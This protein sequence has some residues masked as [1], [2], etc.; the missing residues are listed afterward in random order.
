MASDF[1]LYL[2]IIVQ[3]LRLTL[4]QLA[5]LGLHGVRIAQANNKNI[6]CCLCHRRL[7]SWLWAIKHAH[8]TDVPIFSRVLN[9]KTVSLEGE[10]G[11][12]TRPA[13]YLTFFLLPSLF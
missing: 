9:R 4:H 13:P 5:G 7:Q 12:N 3:A 2:G 11:A 8:R 1:R 10:A 6:S